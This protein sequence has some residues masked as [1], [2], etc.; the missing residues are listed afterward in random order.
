LLS[1]FNIKKEDELFITGY[2]GE[3][4]SFMHQIRGKVFDTICVDNDT[5]K[6]LVFKNIKASGGLNGAPVLKIDEYKTSLVGL[7]VGYDESCDIHVVTCIAQSVQK[8]VVDLMKERLLIKDLEIKLIKGQKYKNKISRNLM[9][10]EEGRP[11]D[12][13]FINTDEEWVILDKTD[14]LE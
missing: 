7:Y 4:G 8:W 2:P 14:L 1:S 5:T 9:K 3:T 6:L 11:T 10:K 13:D 12:M